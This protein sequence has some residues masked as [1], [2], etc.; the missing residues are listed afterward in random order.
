M[1]PI[2]LLIKPSS[3]N[4][5]LRCKYCFYHSIAENRS[6][7][8][9]GMMSFDTLE[10]MVKKALSYA[11]I[12]CTFAFQGGEPTLVGLDFYKRLLEYVKKYNEKKISINYAIQTNGIIIN[13]EWAK[14]FHDNNFLVG[15]SL[16]GYKDIHDMMRYDAKE[17]GT[18]NRVMN[19]VSL[20]NKYKVEFNILCVVNS[21]V[22]RHVNKVYNFF[23]KSGFKFLQFIPCLDPLDKTPGAFDYSLTPERYTVFLKNLFDEWY[24]DIIKGEMISI[25]YFDNLI[26]MAMGYRPESCGMSG[27]CTSYF[28]IESN[29]GVYP[30]DFYVF[31]KWFLGNINDM[32]LEQMQ[33]SDTSQKFVEVSRHIDSECD[34]CDWYSLC[35]GG[36]RR[37]REPFMDGVPA[38]NRYCSSYKEFFKYSNDRIIHLARM[39][40]R[41]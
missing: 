14:F 12:G 39:F 26:S 30:C 5:N 13:D 34:K 16:D 11:D 17:K 24:R 23:K 21:Y 31:D 35:R 10:I 9:H 4:C 37:D 8:S 7:P 33:N 27:I 15:L 38:L 32:E 19:T 2:S 25:R 41:R 28:V 29:G 1:P 6:I 36:C 18:F 20:F 22:A 3:S 40:A